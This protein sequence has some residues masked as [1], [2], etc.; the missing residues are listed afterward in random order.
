MKVVRA[1]GGAC[2]HGGVHYLEETGKNM[3][4]RDPCPIDPPPIKQQTLSC[5]FQKLWG[6]ACLNV[7]LVNR[8]EFF[9]EVCSLAGLLGEGV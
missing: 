9:L 4:I 8:A 1:G 2:L 5:N 3:S 6:R 7:G